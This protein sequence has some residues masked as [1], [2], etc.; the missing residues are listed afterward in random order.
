MIIFL[1]NSPHTCYEERHRFILIM[2]NTNSRGRSY[3]PREHFA[4]LKFHYYL[5]RDCLFC[6]LYFSVITLHTQQLSLKHSYL[7]SRAA[8]KYPLIDSDEGHKDLNQIALRGSILLLLK[9]A[10]IYM[11]TCSHHLFIIHEL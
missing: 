4:L 6:L 11:C 2:S 8:Y 5:H 9:L 1:W 3:I 7:E 10:T